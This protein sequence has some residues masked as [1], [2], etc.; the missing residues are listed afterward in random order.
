MIRKRR[1]VTK[2]KM[3]RRLVCFCIF[4]LVISAA[5]SMALTTYGAMHDI[6]VDLSA[7]LTFIGASFGGELLLLLVKRVTTKNEKENIE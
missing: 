3:A 6:S 7:P 1:V 5:W 2:G 4:V